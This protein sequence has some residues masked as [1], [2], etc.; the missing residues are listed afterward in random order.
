T[1]CTRTT[2]RWAKTRAMKRAVSR[3]V[4]VAPASWGILRTA[5]RRPPLRGLSRR[6]ETTRSTGNRNGT[7]HWTSGRMR[8]GVRRC[9]ARRR[10]AAATKERG[11]EP[12]FGSCV[13]SDALAL[14]GGGENR[15]P[16]GGRI[17][18]EERA[19][20][21]A[22]RPNHALLQ[23]G[24]GSHA[25]GRGRE[26]PRPLAADPVVHVPILGARP[27][28]RRDGGRGVDDH[29]APFRGPRERV[30]IEQ[31]RPPR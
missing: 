21:A 22:D 13:P 10:G 4:S 23:V 12:V 26:G 9:S 14:E 3:L 2:R 6:W 27:D 29:A 25:A 16:R 5:M 1:V 20:R 31:V 7:A 28:L 17:L 8:Q 24:T 30:G 18:V 11:A 15:I 19:L